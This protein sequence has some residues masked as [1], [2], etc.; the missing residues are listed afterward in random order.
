M[1]NTKC[2]VLGFAFNNHKTKVILIKKNRPLWQN[3]LLNGVGGKVELTDIDIYHTMTREFFEETGVTTKEKE[4]H[5]FAD[6]GFDEDIMGGSAMVHCFRLSNDIVNDCKTIESEE[7]IHF[8]LENPCSYPIVSNLNVLI[9]MA[10]DSN[11]NFCK[12]SIL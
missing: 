3:G 1:K 2:Y 8:D 7:I 10:K 9:P 4:W 5:H 6:M 11:F 12:L